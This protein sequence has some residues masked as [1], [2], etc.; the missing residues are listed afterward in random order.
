MTKDLILEALK[1]CR[2]RP[3]RILLPWMVKDIVIN[4]KNVSF[5]VVLTTQP[6]DERHHPQCL[7]E[8]DKTISHKEAV[9]V[10]FTANTST[11]RKDRKS[12]YRK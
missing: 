2:T 4:D 6:S 12:V 10:N 1:M 8:F 5:T 3:A 7:C 9:Q 11:N